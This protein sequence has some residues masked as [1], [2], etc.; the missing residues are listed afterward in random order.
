MQPGR[1]GRRINPD[2]RHKCICGTPVYYHR[3][4][5][6]RQQQK[7]TKLNALLDDTDVSTRAAYQPRST[8]QSISGA[9]VYHQDGV[10]VFQ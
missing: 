8:K 3:G 1:P 6:V 10:A 7:K 2:Q 4:I 5:A 9:A